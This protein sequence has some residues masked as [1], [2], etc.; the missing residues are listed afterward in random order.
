MSIYNYVNWF[1]MYSFLG[2]LLECIVLT[3][4][5]KKPVVDRGFGH[6]PFCVIYGFG[7]VGAC[8]LLSPLADHPVELYTASMTMATTMELITANV[9][10]RLFGSFW[11]DYSHKP[12]NYRGIICLESSLAWGLLGLFFF[13]YLDGWVRTAVDYIPVKLG[14]VMAVVIPIFYLVDFIWCIR[15][16]LGVP[17][18]SEEEECEETVGRLKVY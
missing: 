11:W 10:I 7:A 16:R 14:S 17:E 6:G 12:F 3:I 15:M 2:Y 4:E 13:Y 9:M 1:F 18:G 8:L 5:Y